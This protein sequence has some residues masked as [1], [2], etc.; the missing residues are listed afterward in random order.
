MVDFS[1]ACMAKQEFETLTLKKHLHIMLV[2]L[3][4]AFRMQG[5]G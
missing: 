3:N 2:G 4:P 5:K 1:L